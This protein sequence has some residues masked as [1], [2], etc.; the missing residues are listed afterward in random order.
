MSDT[1]SRIQA[2]VARDD[3]HISEHGYDELAKDNILVSETLLGVPEAVL[4]EDYPERARG[5]S[6][7]TLQR[8]GEGHPIHVVW[9]ITAGQNRPA[10]L[11]TAYRPDQNSWDDDFKRRK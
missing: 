5:P 6:V 7:L 9:A 1:F 2:L 10:V 11:V 8:D 4:V 3:V